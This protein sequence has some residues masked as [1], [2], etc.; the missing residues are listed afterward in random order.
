MTFCSQARRTCG[1]THFILPCTILH[2][3]GIGLP[4]NFEDCWIREIINTTLVRDIQC[5]CS[6]AN[7]KLIY[8]YNCINISSKN[9]SKI[10]SILKL[11]CCWKKSKDFLN[12]ELHSKPTQFPQTCSRNFFIHVMLMMV[13][14]GHS[15]L[16]KVREKTGWLGIICL[17]GATCQLMDYWF[18]ELVW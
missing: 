14:F 13:L 9:E 12:V 10:G 17:N 5:T 2:A 6:K 18:S 3:T 7:R 8:I 15:I 1:T 16:K 11:W 4:P